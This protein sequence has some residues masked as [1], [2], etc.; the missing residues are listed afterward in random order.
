M[1]HVHVFRFQPEKSC[2]VGIVCAWDMSYSYGIRIQSA[3][4]ESTKSTTSTSNTLTWYVHIYIYVVCANKST[5]NVE[6]CSGPIYYSILWIIRKKREILLHI[7]RTVEMLL[8]L[9][10]SRIYMEWKWMYFVFSL[11]LFAVK[12]PC[13]NST[14]IN[15]LPTVIY[16]ARIY[17][18]ISPFFLLLLCIIIYFLQMAYSQDGFWEVRTPSSAIKLKAIPAGIWQQERPDAIRALTKYIIFIKN[19]INEGREVSGTES[20]SLIKRDS[21]RELEQK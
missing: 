7:M 11:N 17:T 6:R 13:I 2:A 14:D 4:T 16:F 5:P 19:W 15:Y 21:C 1:Y 10:A 8:K 18:Y 9:A 12:I 3:S 20:K